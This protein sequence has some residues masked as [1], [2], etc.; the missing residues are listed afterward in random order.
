VRTWFSHPNPWRGGKD[1]SK[2]GSC[3]A[4]VVFSF[5]WQPLMKLTGFLQKLSGE[6]LDVTL[7]NGTVVRGTVI[8]TDVAMNMHLKS[9][10]MAVKGKNQVSMDALSIRGSNVRYIMSVR[11]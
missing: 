2:H 6:T 1:G 7:K 9:V 10:K 8:G 4:A 3:I 11:G 5:L